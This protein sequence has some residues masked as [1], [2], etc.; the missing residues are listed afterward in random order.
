L[1]NYE[2][3]LKISSGD[4]DFHLTQDAVGNGGCVKSIDAVVGEVC[5]SKFSGNLMPG[6]ADLTS[7]NGINGTAS[8]THQ[9]VYKVD[10]SKMSD[11]LTETRACK[12][13]VNQ[14]AAVVE[15]YVS[16]MEED[17]HAMMSRLLQQVC[18]LVMTSART[19]SITFCSFVLKMV[20]HVSL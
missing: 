19:L 7:V 11:H 6:E 17:S 4:K 8:S 9:Q 14:A 2:N 16:V 15:Y 20:M 1:D 3:E 10:E 5:D 13:L 12:D 18:S